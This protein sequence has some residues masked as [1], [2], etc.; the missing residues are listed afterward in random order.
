[1]LKS[2]IHPNA[3]DAFYQLVYYPTKASAG[4]AEIYLTAG[5]NNLY[6]K[7]GRISAND[8]AKRAEELFE[9]DKKL[10]DYY[11]D[12]MSE[13]K[14]KKMMSDKHIGY[15]KW[16]MPSENKLP[17]L[18]LVKPLSKP[19]MG[20]AI[21]GSEDAW[22]ES[23]NKAELPAFDILS[24]QSY[25]IDIFNKGVGSFRFT[26]KSDKSW[27]KLSSKKGTVKK[28]QRIQVDINWKKLPI[29]KSSGL[30][31]ITQG[32]TSIPVYVHVLKEDIPKSS[33]PFYGA[34]TGE[35]S[36]QGYQFSG[37]IPGESAEW[38]LLPDLGRDK[39]CMGISP[40]TAPSVTYDKAPVLEYKI[41][42]P[43]AGK[44]KVC[45]G[46]LPTQDVYPQRGLRI[47]VG[48][49]NMKPTTLDARQGFVDTFREYNAENIKKSNVLK[50]LPPVNKEL[51]LVA[52]GKTRRN[53]I[54]DNIR[55][56]DV[57]LEVLNPG[58]HTLKV[59]MIDPEIVLEKIVL[60][61]YNDRQRYFVSPS[62]KHQ[63]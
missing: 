29:G 50:A 62:K 46:I 55:W 38:I 34:L 1:M 28:D 63:N 48:L 54:F 9:L 13:G 31:T 32:K 6:A 24:N 43:A 33:K 4:V 19:T 30:I 49:N 27:I 61:H 57:D 23:K 52:Y 17:N 12:V 51:A 58:F 45:L 11:N 60:N 21:E 56:L 59:Y 10:S 36:I 26:A 18:M 3:Q 42:L 44:T 25:Y 37:N 2:K 47:A 20:I 14:W 39:G 8:F 41:Y 15:E 22:P 5:W 35:F 53:E 7:Q 40:I 16:H